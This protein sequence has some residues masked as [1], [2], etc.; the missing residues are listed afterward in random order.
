M[1]LAPRAG[2][3]FAA[4]LVIL[5][6]V[7][8]LVKPLYLLGIDR[9]VQN[10]VGTEAYGLYATLF[11]FTFLFG[12]VYDLG[13]QNY[14]SVTLS[15]DP[16]LLA[17]RLPIML[18]LKLVIS[19][20]YGALVLA[21]A[22]LV[23][24]RGQALVLAGLAALFHVTLS[25]FQ[26]LRTNLAAQE[27]YAFNSVVSVVDKALLIVVLG[28]ILLSQLAPR[29]LTVAW[30]FALQIAAL[31]VA[32]GVTVTGTRRERGQR[33]FAWRP[34]QQVR[35]L[36][37]ALP[38]GLT[39]F[40]TT[41]FTRLDIFMVE[42]M[43]SRGAF[44][45][46]VYAASYRLLDGVNMVGFLFATL[47][48]PMLSKLVIAG[49]PARALLR[50]SAGYMAALGVGVAAYA[51]FFGQ[52]LMEALY[53]EAEPGW[54]AVLAALMWAAV[55]VGLTYVYGSFLL[56]HQR[57]AQLN[58]LFGVALVVNVGLNAWLIPR[59]GAL[60]AALAT[61]VTQL[62]V[63][64]SEFWWSE[65]LEGGGLGKWWPLPA[66]ILLCVGGGWGLR[67]LGVGWPTGLLLEGGIALAVGIALG[68]LPRSLAELRQQERGS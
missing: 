48:L 2:R 17:E 23:G 15:K 6:G 22:Y 49:E 13:L 36:R 1:S 8:A 60:G 16:A 67:T 65:G 61:V 45:A 53:V 34:A 25:T 57:V 29:W 21:A 26:L 4:N 19:L 64:A 27:R 32:I 28:P 33:W 44:E 30:F 39:L 47:L 41:A 58:A 63:A 5:L 38:F 59:Y 50:Q 40:L 42:R 7:N 3:S 55:G 35:L 62:G 24:Y 14:N 37:A 68:L 20:G 31:A 12:V 18:S 46:G 66:Y 11:G 56:A 10:A 51:S 54:G 52:P 9:G 43:A